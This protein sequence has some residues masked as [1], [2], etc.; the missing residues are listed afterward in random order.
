MN[1]TI[2]ILECCSELA[3]LAVRREIC[4]N[5]SLEEGKEEWEKIYQYVEDEE[6]VIIYT[7]EAQDCFIRWYDYYFDIIINLSEDGK[8]TLLGPSKVPN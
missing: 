4:D 6:N 5:E 8:D 1:V 7:E 3:D 2:N